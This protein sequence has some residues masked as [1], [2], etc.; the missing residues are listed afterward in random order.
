MYMI[1]DLQMYVS[2]QCRIT[3]SFQSYFTYL[4]RIRVF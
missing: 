2:V 1:Y 3:M 4:E